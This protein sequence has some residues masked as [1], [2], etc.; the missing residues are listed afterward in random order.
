M[1]STN[2]FVDD[3]KSDRLVGLGGGT[4]MLAVPS[5]KVRVEFDDIFV[6]HLVLDFGKRHPPLSFL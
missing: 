5:K 1:T 2:D 4:V 6:S 3:E